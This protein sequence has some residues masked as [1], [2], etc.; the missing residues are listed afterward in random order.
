ML[1]LRQAA[2]LRGGQVV[3]MDRRRRVFEGDLLLAGGRI[4]ALGPRLR[5]PRGA[6]VVDCRGKAVLPGLVQAHVHLCQVLLRNRADGLELLDWLRRRIWPMEAAHDARSLRFSARLGIA[7]LLLG[8]TTAV[9]DMATVQH[10][11]QV[12]LAA[13]ESGLRYTGGK[14][15]MDQ[16][17]G[18]PAGLRDSTDGALAEALALARRWHGAAEGRLGYALC[19][20]FVLSCSEPLLRR[21]A[22]LSRSQG[23]IVHTHAS[24]NPLE[25]RLV[26]KIVGDDNAAYFHQLGLHGPRVVLAHCVHLTE[27]EEKLM[28]RA[29]THAVHC[30]GANLKL[31]SGIAPLPRLRRRGVPLALGGDGA[32]CNNTLDA[33]HEMRLA[34][35]LH[36]P[37]F[38]PRSVP[39][40]EVLEMA[41]LGG[42]RA[43]GLG[44]EIGSLEPDKKAD[45]T[46]VDLERPHLSPR[47]A[48]LHATLVYGARASDVT[49]VWVDGRRLV[50]GGT[51]RTLDAAALVAAAPAEQARLLRRARLKA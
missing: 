50:A 39:A 1:P 43:L 11:E 5:T 3:T 40:V 51:L 14:A 26:R 31:G 24:E 27:R 29:G 45:V 34:A 19:P 35:T 12:F 13:E 23:W 42:A 6:R 46:V 49:D 2:L 8:G 47:G 25:T 10:T 18:L 9:L 41:T 32:P 48:D 33:F 20:R 44:D 17:A 30:P 7:E 21:V 36:L 38:G 28:A 15:L 37:R 16:G 22:E 4:A